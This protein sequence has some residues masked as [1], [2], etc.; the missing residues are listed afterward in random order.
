MLPK[1]IKVHNKVSFS[2]ATSPN[3]RA[4]RADPSEGKAGGKRGAKQAQPLK[5]V[6]GQKPCERLEGEECPQS[7]DKEVECE[8]A[9]VHGERHRSTHISNGYNLAC[10]SVWKAKHMAVE[11]GF[12]DPCRS[13]NRRSIT[14]MSMQLLFIHRHNSRRKWYPRKRYPRS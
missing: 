2:G 10:G 3:G 6:E 8:R 12:T 7:Q 9:A 4:A 1:C 14:Q 13:G 11:G 5:L